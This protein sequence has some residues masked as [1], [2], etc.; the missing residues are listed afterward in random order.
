[1]ELVI[2]IAGIILIFKFSTVLNAIASMFKAKSEVVAEQVI[3]ECVEER[4]DNFEDFKKR[5]EG[6]NIYTHEEIIQA[7]KVD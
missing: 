4:T 1:M 2:A 3:A 5:M 6:K 7:F